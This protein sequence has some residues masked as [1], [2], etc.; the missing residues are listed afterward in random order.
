VRK[1]TAAIKIEDFMKSQMQILCRINFILSW[2]TESR[3]MNET[4]IT[5][6]ESVRFQGGNKLPV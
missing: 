1:T 2:E 6:T 3:L 5:L 4:G